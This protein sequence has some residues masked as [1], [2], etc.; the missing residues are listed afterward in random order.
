ME[1]EKRKPAKGWRRVSPT[2]W[3]KKIHVDLVLS[4]QRYGPQEGVSEFLWDSTMA[5]FGSYRRCGT[6][7]G[8]REE[9]QLAAEDA[10]IKLAHAIIKRL[11]REER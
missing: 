5:A 4:V 7:A 1:A 10:A 8:S 6:P 9:A 3:S 2:L 11:G